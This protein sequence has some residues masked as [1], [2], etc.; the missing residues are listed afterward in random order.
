MHRFIALLVA[1]IVVATACGADGPVEDALEA[2]GLSEN[3]DVEA[4]PEPATV[5]E[6]LA[7]MEAD[8][9]NGIVMIDQPGS[10]RVTPMGT[11]DGPG[12]QPVDEDTVFD[13][14]SIT[15]Q[16]TGAAVV[17]LEM[18]GMVSVED[19]VGD[20]LGELDGP[21]ADVTLHQ[22]L[23]HTAGLPD[24]IGDDD[25]P[26]DRAEFV[27]RAMARA[28]EPGDYEY[29]NAGYSLLGM[30]IEAASGMGYEAYLREVFFE[31]AGMGSTGYVLAT[32]DRR[33]VAVG[34]DGGDALGAPDEQNWADDGPWWNLRANGGILST[35]ADM[36]RWHDALSEDELLSAE[37][38]DQ[39]FARHVEEGPDSGTFYGYGWVS[40]PLEDGSWFHGHNGGN[41]IFFADVLR[42]AD[43][44][45]LIFLATSHAGADEDAAFRL[46][47]ALVEGGVGASCLPPMD[48]MSFA[49]SDD[50][51]DSAA[52]DTAQAM[53]DIML[54][55][56][57]AERR[58]FAETHVSEELAGGAS[59]DEQ[60][61]QLAALQ[62]EFAGA[63]VE[64]V[65]VED[66]QR[67]HIVLAS[68]FAEPLVLSVHV[69]ETDPVLITCVQIEAL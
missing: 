52:G 54:G 5:D 39:L 29:S 35:A 1:V 34:Y 40:F 41:G 25:E 37:A 65:R 58:R 51:P 36:R 12:S 30:V 47:D 20:Y 32:F 13:I 38:K 64:M 24:S 27:Q 19:R 68:D 31:P 49:G 44:D 17:R 2:V 10:L 69:D 6:L 57:A 66:A 50:Y 22:L 7:Q 3:V 48:V 45:L 4:P 15:K 62:E 21:L 16:F 26:I 8:G 60:V 67:V 11:V 43:D 46:A 63:T 61:A 59:I 18:D 33:K 56:D 53:V 9:F 55:G 14:G 23:T 28:G 42:F